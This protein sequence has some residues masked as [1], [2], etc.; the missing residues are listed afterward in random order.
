[1]TYPDCKTCKHEKTCAVKKWC[2]DLKYCQYV[3]VNNRL[4]KEE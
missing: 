2:L 3:E 1:M 4:E